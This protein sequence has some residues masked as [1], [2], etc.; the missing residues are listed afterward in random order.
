MSDTYRVLLIID[1]QAEKSAL[2]ELPEELA[3]LDMWSRIEIPLASSHK[4][5]IELRRIR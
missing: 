4:F 2:I 1:T 3:P 5:E